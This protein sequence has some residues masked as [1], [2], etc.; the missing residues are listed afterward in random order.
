MA[1][2]QTNIHLSFFLFIHLTLQNGAGVE[3][4]WKLLI[5][6]GRRNFFRYFR[7]LLDLGEL[8]SIQ[9]FYGIGT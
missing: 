9:E 5:V 8:D 4:C 2:Y 3:T 7:L 1:H 6:N